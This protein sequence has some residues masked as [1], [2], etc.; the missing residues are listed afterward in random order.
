MHLLIQPSW[1]KILAFAVSL[2][3]QA[4]IAGIGVYPDV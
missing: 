4:E 3:K 1:F 2:C